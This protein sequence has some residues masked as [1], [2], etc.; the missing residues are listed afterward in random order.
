[1]EKKNFPLNLALLSVR[2]LLGIT[3][4]EVSNDRTPKKTGYQ[5]LRNFFLFDPQTKRLYDD[6]LYSEK[7]KQNVEKILKV[8]MTSFVINIVILMVSA[9]SFYRQK[10]FL[11]NI[12]KLIIDGKISSLAESK[13]MVRIGIILLSSNHIYNVLKDFIKD[14]KFRHVLKKISLDAYLNS[15]FLLKKFN[16]ILPNRILDK[17]VQELILLIRQYLNKNHYIEGM[18]IFDYVNEKIKK[19]EAN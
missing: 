12:L 9:R 5:A 11:S 18:P 8:Y 16:S 17:A 14:K 1:M 2:L 7:N 15:I 19:I 4:G 6:D 13:N 10:N 3:D